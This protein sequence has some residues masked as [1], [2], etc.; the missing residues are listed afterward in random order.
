MSTGNVREIYKTPKGMEMLT[1]STAFHSYSQYKNWGPS[2]EM[3]WGRFK[4]K[5]KGATPHNSAAQ[6][7]AT[8]CRNCKS[9]LGFEKQLD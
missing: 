2:T 3:A 1:G 9:L 5:A 6:L 7:F 8:T 4:N